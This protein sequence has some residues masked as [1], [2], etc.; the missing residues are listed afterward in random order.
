MSHGQY[1]PGFK[2]NKLKSF[3]RVE[4]DRTH[5][6]LKDSRGKG[7]AVRRL[8]KHNFCPASVYI[9]IS[10]YIYICMHKLW[11]IS[12]GTCIYVHKKSRVCVCACLCLHTH[13][14]LHNC[15]MYV[16]VS[17]EEDLQASS[18]YTCPNVQ[19]YLKYRFSVLLYAQKYQK[20]QIYL[21]QCPYY[22]IAVLPFHNLSHIC[23]LI[24]SYF[25]LN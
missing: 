21:K 14:H 4:I 15:D 19:K 22:N 25:D 7:F 13:T 18:M 20:Y 9:Y 16:P 6:D 17:S 2:F 1:S 5:V 12:S 24:L 11:F 23:C 3:S 10:I 8:N